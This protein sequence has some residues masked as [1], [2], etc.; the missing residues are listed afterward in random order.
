MENTIIKMFKDRV[1]SVDIMASA[2]G[3]NL[4]V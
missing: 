4:Y 1:V 3:I 2:G